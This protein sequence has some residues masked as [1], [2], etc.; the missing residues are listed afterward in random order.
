MDTIYPKKQKGRTSTCICK[1][2]SSSYSFHTA[3]LSLFGEI[4]LSR[5]CK[6]AGLTANMCVCNKLTPLSVDHPNVTRSA[7]ASVNHIN[8]DLLLNH[9]DICETLALKEVIDAQYMNGD[10]AG[11]T[12]YD[13]VLM[14]VTEPGGAVFDATVRHS[15][16]HGGYE[17][18]GDIA[19][20]SWYG[21][22]ASCI[23]DYYIRF[24]CYCKHQK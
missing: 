18:Q 2:I 20:I 5:T 10:E 19:R 12:Y 21:S 6:D 15:V 9:S 8:N 16:T 14:F 11:Q 7:Y 17:V 23:D 3:G 24:Y 1:L 4:P 22:T 13:Y